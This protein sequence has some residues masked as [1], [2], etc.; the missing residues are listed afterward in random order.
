MNLI[1]L[2]LDCINNLLKPS[3]NIREIIPGWDDDYP[4]P[5][6]TDDWELT[7]DIDVNEDF[8]ADTDLEF[9][10][11]NEDETQ[12]LELIDG[13][14]SCKYFHGHQYNDIDLICAIH[15][16]G[17]TNCSNF[18]PKYATDSNDLDLE[19]DETIWL[20]EEDEL[21]AQYGHYYEFVREQEWIGD[22]LE[23]YLGR[24]N[25]Q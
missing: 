24:Y 7:S 19:Q 3:H 25:N 16:Y 6:F 15:P 17:N 11:F 20:T 8:E 5:I 9:S 22:D 13:C 23:H 18:E 21:R 1:K 2:A 4:D 10:E 14:T 12:Y